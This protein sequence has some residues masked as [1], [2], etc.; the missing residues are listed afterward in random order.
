MNTVRRSNR[1][2]FSKIGEKGA[3]RTGL[4]RQGVQ[5]AAGGAGDVP[6]LGERQH[7]VAVGHGGQAA[8]DCGHRHI[9]GDPDH[10]RRDSQ[11]TVGRA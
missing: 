11:V 8:V 10:L 5:H 3:A 2:H 6:P 4:A 1:V 9:P 7:P